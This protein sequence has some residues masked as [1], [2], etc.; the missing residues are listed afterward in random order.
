MLLGC[1]GNDSYGSKISENLEKVNVKPLLEIREDVLSSRCGVGICKKERCLVPQIR[2]STMLSMDFVNNNM[3]EINKSELIFIEGYFIIEKYDIV[4]SLVSKFNESNKKVGF[5]LSATFIID[6]FYDK[7]HEISN[8]SDL[9]FCNEDEAK[10]FAKSNSDDMVEVSLAIH[11]LL[12]PR[13][14]II[15]VT[16]GS[17]PVVITEMRNGDIVQQIIHPV[18]KLSK[19]EIVDTNG[20]GDCKLIFL[21]LI[22]HLF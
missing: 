8:C 4:K 9:I 20:C 15:I 11:K 10:A 18:E 12:T 19:D 1:I 6:N 21:S 2:A 13:N 7:V 16:C 14:R 5:T 17:E 22:F 3:S